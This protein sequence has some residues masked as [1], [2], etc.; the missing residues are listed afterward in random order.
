MPPGAS[1]GAPKRGAVIFLRHEIYKKYVS[2]V[3]AVMHGHGRTNHARRTMRILNLISS[4][5]L[6]GP[7]NVRKSL[8]AGAS[9]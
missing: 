6:L 7:Q 1:R 8:T 9:P 5:R 2:S 3:E 4:V